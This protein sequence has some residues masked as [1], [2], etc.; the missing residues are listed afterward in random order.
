VKI[1]VFALILALPAPVMA[2]DWIVLEFQGAQMSFTL[3][4]PLAR[5]GFTR[6]MSV[7]AVS[8]EGVAGPARLA[9]E[10]SLPPGGDNP[11][12]ARIMFRPDGYRDYWLSPLAFPK[13]G[14]VID[15]LTFSGPDARISGRFETPL[16]FTATA[17]TLPDPA[18]CDLARGQFQT[19]LQP[20]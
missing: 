12:D 15:D 4:D 6:F 9:I 8:F 17:L 3:D 5:A 20:D 1:G 14:V 10:L 2:Q 13:G 7:D 16:C 18:N 11:H 19:G